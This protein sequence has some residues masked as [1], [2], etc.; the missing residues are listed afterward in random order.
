MAEE[1]IILLIDEDGAVSAKSSGFKGEAC[2]DALDKLL[3]PKSITSI[4]TTDEYAQQVNSI[5]LAKI[6]VKG[7]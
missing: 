3:G 6:N 2:L 4:K 5:S 7:R 1:K